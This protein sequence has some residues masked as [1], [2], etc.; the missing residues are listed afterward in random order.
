MNPSAAQATVIVDELVRAGV[1]HVVLCP[2]SRNAPLSFALH[3]AEET[4]ALSLH[5][6]ID[7]RSAGF[8]TLGLSKGLALDGP[9]TGYAAVVCTSGTAVANL[10]PAVLEATHSDEPIVLLTADRPP[11]QVGSGASQTTRQHGIFE[12]AVSTVDFP[13][14]E[15]RPGQNAIW[16]GLLSRALG[17]A[18]GPVHLNV[19]FREP[20]V[21][22]GSAWPDSLAGRRDGG[23]WTRLTPVAT[24]P[25]PARS[26]P[27]RTLLVIGTATFPAARQAAEVAARVGW[28]VIAEPGGEQGAVAAGADVLR[29]GALLVAAELPERL[30]PEA[31]VVVGRPTLG[32]GVQRLLREAPEVHLIADSIGYADPQ[33]V[34]TSV[35][36]A[37]AAAGGE[38]DPAWSASWL[39]ADKLAAQAV[40][41][42]LAARPWPTGLQVGRDLMSA[43]PAGST[44][45]LGSSNVVRDVE[46][47]AAGRADVSV[48]VSR[49]LAGIDGSISTAAG[50]SLGSGRPGYALLGDLTFLHE[51]GGLLIGPAERRPDLSIVVLNDDGGGIF[52]LLEQGSAEYAGSFERVFGTPHGADLAALCAGYAVPFVR[53]DSATTL[54]AA[55]SPP[56][57]LRVVE[58]RTERAGLRDLHAHL[59]DAVADALR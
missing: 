41:A 54:S 4:G 50:I 27:A 45:F 59:R 57:G 58:V 49:G 22:S 39:A 33:Y 16:R 55:L 23:P 11:E 1:R 30:H 51:V 20:L 46:L 19:P 18:R 47:A 43:V 12:P 34:A 9:R 25:A 17:A 40:E 35:A 44:L 48:V 37:L 36:P 7:E 52:S 29:H 26:F 56:S 21:P 10:H 28:P 5:V 53:A 6:R 32:R 2:G 15:R 31:V 14:A 42:A 24:P 13:V 8:L 3:A 38:P